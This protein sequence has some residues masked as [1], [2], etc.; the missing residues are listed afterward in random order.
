MPNLPYLK[1]VTLIAFR[2]IFFALFENVW[3]LSELLLTSQQILT[4]SCEHTRILP[5]FS[6]AG[7]VW[8][9]S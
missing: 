1:T 9:Q 8:T 5:L 6:R 7:I 4:A 3:G 2:V